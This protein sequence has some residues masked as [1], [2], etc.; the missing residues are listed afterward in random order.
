MAQVIGRDFAACNNE[1]WLSDKELQLGFDLLQS[2]SKW[3]RRI[4]WLCGIA[5][6]RN[7]ASVDAR[8]E[9]PSGLSSSMN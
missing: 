1:E 7:G 8:G 2:N 3:Q 6:R 9:Q 4:Y 5:P